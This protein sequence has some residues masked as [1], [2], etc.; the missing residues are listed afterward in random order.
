VVSIVIPASSTTFPQR[1]RSIFAVVVLA[2]LAACGGG[3]GSA[4]GGSTPPPPPVSNAPV[5]QA[6][7]TTLGAENI[8]PQ[9]IL[10]GHTSLV[11]VSVTAPASGAPVTSAAVMVNGATLT[12]QPELKIYRGMIDLAQEAPVELS[13]ISNGVTY[14]ASGRQVPTFL[15]LSSP[16]IS[17]GAYEPFRSMVQL[18]RSLPTLVTWHGLLPAAEFHYAVAVLDEKGDLAWPQRA[19]FQ[20]LADGAP[21]EAILPAG[22]VPPGFSSVMAGIVR[23]F[24]IPGAAGGSSL[25]VGNFSQ[26][27]VDSVDAAV[28]TLVALEI[29]QQDVA[30]APGS[31]HH[32]IARGSYEYYTQHLQ[33]DLTGSVTWTSDATAI[34]RVSTTGKLTGVAPG[35]ATVTARF[36]AVSATKTVTVFAPEQ[37]ESADRS[38]AFQGDSTHAGRRTYS[39]P[40]SLPNQAA[41]SV[42]LPGRI[43]YPLIADGTVFVLAN[44]EWDGSSTDVSLH[45]FDADTGAAKWNTVVD[46]RAATSGQTYSKNKVIVM[47][48]KGVLTAYDAGTGRQAWSLPLAERVLN[49][50]AFHSPPTAYRGVVYVS[51]YGVGSTLNAIDAETGTLLWS[52]GYLSATGGSPAVYGDTVYVSGR[53]QHYALDRYTGAVRW[54]FSG[55]GY[56]GGGATPAL[57][58]GKVYLREPS[59][60][61]MHRIDALTGAGAAGDGLAEGQRTPSSNPAEISSF[62]GSRRFE[63]RDGELVAID[64]PTNRVLWRFTGNGQLFSAPFTV[65]DTVFVASMN[66]KLFAVDGTTGT[67]IWQYQAGTQAYETSES[68]AFNLPGMASAGGML[69]VPMGKVLSAFKLQPK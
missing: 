19:G 32:L 42:T 33:Q 10:R 68:N 26:S 66:G 6:A 11:T 50:W 35:T 61:F 53:L 48:S 46:Q 15:V 22:A 8:T 47:N 67:E 5:I 25:V 36:G 57:Y 2:V 45:A 23:S 41:W 13:V 64:I 60:P 29:T 31:E 49:M 38:V 9:F 20:V 24:G 40:F 4:P 52:S 58:N 16:Q 51:G 3:G 59:A 14:Q 44:R 18:D 62:S 28:R 54:H 65:N 21:T 17:S 39:G 69:V 34:V 1:V 30:L 55:D 27:V 7:I 63:L 37:D 56:G 12:Y 43:S